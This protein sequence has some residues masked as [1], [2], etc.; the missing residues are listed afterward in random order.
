MM[1][2]RDPGRFRTTRCERFE[3]MNQPGAQC[4]VVGE[5]CKGERAIP[6]SHLRVMDR[7]TVLMR[8]GDE[9]LGD[10]LAH[11]L[12]RKPRRPVAEIGILLREYRQRERHEEHCKVQTTLER[13]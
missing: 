12:G 10:L 2:H 11:L 8:A 13:N 4:V 1:P 7:R 5:G 3:A 6:G 9:M